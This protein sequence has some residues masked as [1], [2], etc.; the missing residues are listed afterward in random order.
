MR[1]GTLAIGIALCTLSACGDDLAN[2]ADLPGEPGRVGG[3]ELGGAPARVDPA[4]PLGA[5]VLVDDAALASDL[6]VAGDRLYWVAPGGEGYLLRSA[7]ADGSGEVVTVLDLGGLAPVDLA[8]AGG[9]V[10]WATAGRRA[11]RLHRF[12]LASGGA[13]E[14]LYQDGDARPTAIAAGGRH[15]YFG[16]TD[17]CVRRLGEAGRPERVACGAG[18]P[19]V[20]AA[21]RTD[22]FWGTAEG[23]L[24]Q[25]AAA[26]GAADQRLAD[27]SFHSRLFIDDR[28]IYWLDAYQRAVQVMERDARSAKQLATAQYAPVGMAASADDV[29]FTTQSDQSVKRVAKVS[30][31]VEVLAREQ[32]DPADI[33]LH[34]ERA[35]WINEADGTIMSLPVR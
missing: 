1:R 24:Y 4:A 33:A 6:R 28:A 23:R 15:V 22:V 32:A 16:A 13:V 25:A 34:G 11:G 35:F 29:Y 2:Q 30:S 26:G 21:D 18:T 27:E 12:A 14:V 19:V 9:Q 8:F 17:G 3:E 7:R 5:E 31:P 20:I 10:Y